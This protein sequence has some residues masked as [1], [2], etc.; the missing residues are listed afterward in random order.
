M[1]RIYF[2]L[3]TTIF[4]GLFSLNNAYASWSFNLSSVD[5]THFDLNFISDEGPVEAWNYTFVI[6]YSD[7]ITITDF[8]VFS[9]NGF[10]ALGPAVHDAG[11]REI[12]NISGMTFSS[13][14]LTDGFT[15]AS[16]TFETLPGA[17]K[18]S[19][20]DVFFDI[21]NQNFGGMF[22][23][24]D[25]N[26]NTFNGTRLLAENHLTSDANLD[27]GTA[28]TVPI[29]SSFLLLGCGLSALLGVTRR[30]S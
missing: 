17:E 22:E 29:S 12:S 10:F 16:F 4:L 6:G 15:F 26:T 8:S 11:E 21:S 28:T 19:I 24:Q 30:K 2:L 14:S 5:D 18:D 23:G 13:P 3:F 20:N 7:N 25:S 27:V 1:K 9:P